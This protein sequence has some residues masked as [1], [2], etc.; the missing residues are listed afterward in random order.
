MRREGAG[1]GGVRGPPNCARPLPELRAPLFRI[2]RAALA[3]GGDHLLALLGRVVVEARVDLRLLVLEV[4]VHRED[5]HLRELLRHAGV[6]AAV[7]HHEALDEARLHP[8]LVLHVHDLDH[9]QVDRRVRLAHA[10]HGVDHHL[11]ELVGELDVHLRAERRL[12]D[13]QQQR[14]VGAVLGDAHRVEE[15]EHRALRRLDP[16]AQQPR[17]HAVREVALRLLHDLAHDQHRRRRAVAGRVV[18]R[19]RD[20]RDHARGGVLDLHLRQQ[21]LPVLRELD[22]ARARHQH[23]QGALRAEVRLEDVL[24]PA[25]RVDVH[26]RRVALL[27]HVRIRV[28]RL[29]CRGTHR[30]AMERYV[31]VRRCA[32]RRD[33][34]GPLGF[35]SACGASRL[36]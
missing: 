25:R 31:S 9:V 29:R 35:R 1:A 20:P 14:A 13:L 22:V 7:V 3:L 11:G 16:L 2:A 26:V 27:E 17:V 6:A 18:L 15:L 23:L 36:C 30:G 33:F 12:R 19:R 5:A 10:Q 28:D 8:R 34:A 4:D 21:H 32:G 24:Q